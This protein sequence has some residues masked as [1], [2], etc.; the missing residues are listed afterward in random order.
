MKKIIFCKLDQPYGEFSNFYRSFMVIDRKIYLTNE[1][2]Y[3][4]Q[5]FVGNKFEEIVRIQSSPMKAKRIARSIEAEKY[6][7]PDWNDI[8]VSVMA[9]GLYHKFKNEILRNLLLSTGNSEIVEYSNKDKF[10]GR[11]SENDG[12]NILGKMLMELREQ[13][14]AEENKKNEFFS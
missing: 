13:I 12:Q 4:S 8:K 9:K 5:K 10:W 6:L 2:Y 11:N 1:H 7:R 14:R 3:Q